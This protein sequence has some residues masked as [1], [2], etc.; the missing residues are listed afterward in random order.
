MDRF[1]NIDWNPPLEDILDDV[2]INEERLERESVMHRIITNNFVDPFKDINEDYKGVNIEFIKSQNTRKKKNKKC[3][4]ATVDVTGITP[5]EH[6]A[7]ERKPYVPGILKPSFKFPRTSK[8][9]KSQQNICLRVLIRFS[10]SDKPEIGE[11][12]RKELKCYM[13]M[14]Q[15]IAQEQDEFLELAKSKWSSESLKIACE[16]YINTKWKSKMKYVNELPRYYTEVGSIP[17]AVNDAISLKFISTCLQLGNVAKI[18]IPTFTRPY[19]L[20]R[21]STRLQNKYPPTRH[22]CSHS[23]VHSKLPV[24]E[25]PNCQKLV[26]EH[27]VD[28]VISSSGL[29]CLVNNIG[30]TYLKSWILP[31]VVKVHHGKNVAYI[32]KSAPPTANT[33][34]E[35]N[36]WVYKY[37]V[38]N[39]MVDN[40][41]RD[42][43]SRVSETDANADDNDLFDD[44]NSDDVLKLEDEYQS[45][46]FAMVKK[47]TV[48]EQKQNADIHC[49]NETTGISSKNIFIEGNLQNVGR[50]VQYTSIENDQANVSKYKESKSK[51][52]APDNVSYNL[53]YIGPQ[54]IEQE[55]L[56]RNNSKV[57]KILVRT[58]TDG[59]E[60]LESG[61][62]RMS[63]LAPK[64]EHQV[65]LGA[66]AVT[67][68][69]ALKQWISL[70]FRPDTFLIRV[71]ISADTSEILQLERRT[72]VSLSN[73]I[74]RLYNINAESS[75]T[76]LH[77]II[78][79]LTA[80][81]PGRY[82]I[83][84]TVR[85]GAFA[86]L[87]TEAD[88]P[89][90]NVFD[91]HTM[92]ENEYHT[93]PN[94]P[95]PLLD[96]TVVT[97]MQKCFGRMPAMFYPSKDTSKGVQSRRSREGKHN[98]AINTKNTS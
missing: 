55:E 47:E 19:I 20:Y 98:V 65:A 59:V 66:E 30:P 29:N 13:D 60:E 73:E 48:Q 2:F 10:E 79:T 95:W 32:D 9:D 81:P 27:D 22:T 42:P 89:G 69:E 7:L 15:V 78:Q 1:L 84:H 58:K 93:L 64:L 83:R 67:L 91:L 31:V 50:K 38:R 85:N 54:C 52:C 71:R 80:Q 36:T 49:K 35:K 18:K 3:K 44:V 34:P 23:S 96:K 94:A 26:E 33:V 82:V 76:V 4:D 61:A 77:N 21:N 41:Q 56:M 45:G 17:L 75:L 74:K 88:G 43:R 46:S 53:F 70:T 68:D 51:T 12:E 57:F 16:N 5:V 39:F 6:K 25:D 87:N 63:L 24:N 97:P 37:I 14:Q 90:K 40:G 72:T 28:L 62:F 8:L 11:M 92:C 86:T